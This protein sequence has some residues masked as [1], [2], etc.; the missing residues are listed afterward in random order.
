MKEKKQILDN[1]EILIFHPSTSISTPLKLSYIILVLK[2]AWLTLF[3]LFNFQF[4][5]KG[6][7]TW[8]LVKLGVHPQHPRKPEQEDNL[9]PL[10]HGVGVGGP[11]VVVEDEDCTDNAT[12]HHHHDEREVNANQGS[13]T[14]WWHHRRNL[15]S[16]SLR[17][18]IVQYPLRVLTI[19]V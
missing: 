9:D 14:C 10:G 17:N 11:L 12:G 1:D 15:G 8:G 19:E 16:N 5:E 4:C 18:S 6:R 13:V 3:L 7:I 2:W